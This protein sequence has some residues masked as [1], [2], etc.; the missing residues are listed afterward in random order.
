MDRVSAQPTPTYPPTK[1]PKYHAKK[2]IINGITFA[3]QK[4]GKRYQELLLL[5]K[6]GII[7]DLGIQPRFTL[8]EAFRASTHEWFKSIVYVADFT[9]REGNDIVVED[10][11]GFETPVFKI[12]K[13]LF[14]SRYPK[15]KFIQ[16]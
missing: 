6:A 9:Y 13:K 15:L 16:S 14:L 1:E 11:K 2:C 12:K 3:S 8:L 5:L 7:T 4:E 10:T